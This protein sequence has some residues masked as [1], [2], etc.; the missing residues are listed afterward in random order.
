MLLMRLATVCL[1]IGCSR[2]YANTSTPP[3]R[4]AP[5]SCDTVPDRWRPAVRDWQNDP[6]D[7]TQTIVDPAHPSGRYIRARFQVEIAPG[8]AGPDACRLLARHHARVM[9]GYQNVS[10]SASYVIAVPDPGM[11]WPTWTALEESLRKDPDFTSVLKLLYGGRLDM[12]D[13]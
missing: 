3:D 6:I 7:S 4:V 9:G 10:G 5:G 1:A 8:L 11:S 12:G 2:A 13:R